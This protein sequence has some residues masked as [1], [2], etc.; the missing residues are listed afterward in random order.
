MTATGHLGLRASKFWAMSMYKITDLVHIG[1]TD[2][3][4]IHFL[5]NFSFSSAA[6]LDFEKTNALGPSVAWAVSRRKSPPNLLRI[7]QT[8][9][10]LLKV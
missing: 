6:I 1:R 4:V 10:E 8:V 5:V 7:G 9:R 2:F 3:E